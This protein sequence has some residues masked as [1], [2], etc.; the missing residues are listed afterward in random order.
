MTVVVARRSSW[1]SVTDTLLLMGVLSA[2]D[3]LPQ[4]LMQ[5]MFVGAL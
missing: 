5:A 4:Y 2:T 1:F 3:A